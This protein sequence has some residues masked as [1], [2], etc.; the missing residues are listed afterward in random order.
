MVS[1]TA[2][3]AEMKN[4]VTVVGR[5]YNQ[6]GGVSNVMAQLATRASSKYR[7]S[8]AAN[9][10]LDWNSNLH[11]VPVPMIT[12]PAWAQIPSFAAAAR[13]RVT[14]SLPDIIHAHDPQLIGADIYTAHSCFKGY[15]GGQR[16]AADIPRRFL[17]HVFPP[18]VAGIMMSNLAY[19]SGSKIVAVSGSIKSE[20]IR[21]HGIAPERIHVVYNGVDLEKFKPSGR[22]EAKQRLSREIG[23]DLQEKVVLIF[24]GY[25]FERKRLGVVLRALSSVGSDA[26]HLLVVGG[27][28]TTKYRALANE[29][30]VQ[31]MTTFLGHREDVPNLLRASDIFVFPTKYEAASLAILEAAAAGLAMITTDVAMASEVFTDG[32]D[33]LLVPN[34][35]SH[36]A[37][38]KSLTQ[39]IDD[40]DLRLRLGDSANALAQDFG[41]DS[42][43]SQ[44]DDIYSEALS[45]KK[46]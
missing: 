26:C 1:P 29:L 23:V 8:V 36:A 43:W 38:S 3:P 17:S 25:E 22:P 44:Y 6:Q 40:R 9:E 30:G 41:W 24:V 39:L 27:A 34:S 28:D 42:I 13:P 37:V 16:L 12:K 15:I 10:Y 20:L 11:K 33:A 46:R 7:V 35:D 19:R 45:R 21:E 14:A 5:Y 32:A 31:G 18:H 4:S 2:G